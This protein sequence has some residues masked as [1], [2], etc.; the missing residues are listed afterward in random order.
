MLVFLCSSPP[1][2]IHHVF[3]TVSPFGTLGET[4]SFLPVVHYLL[5]LPSPISGSSLHQNPLERV[6]LPL[7][8]FSSR[9]NILIAI[10]SRR[11]YFLSFLLQKPSMLKNSSRWGS[12]GRRGVQQEDQKVYQWFW[13]MTWED[14]ICMRCAMH[15]HISLYPYIHTYIHA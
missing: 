2:T 9:V 12:F 4:S 8:C 13:K 7:D 1:L 14:I 6:E 3:G 15:V 10:V 11:L 5:S